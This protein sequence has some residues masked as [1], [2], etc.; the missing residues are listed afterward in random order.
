M[1]RT[2]VIQ[3]GGFRTAF[4]AGVL[5][6]FQSAK[7]NPFD[8][9]VA[10]SGGAIALS[11]Y[12]SRQPKAYY[13]AL[14]LLAEDKFFMDWSRIV[15]SQGVMN[16]DYFRKV[17]TE[18]IPLAVERAM[19][20]LKDKDIAIVLTN[21]TSGQPHYFRPDRKHW[22]D[23]IIATCTLPF[24]TKGSHTLKGEHFMDGGWSDPLPV[25]WAYE[26]GATELVVIRTTPS[27]VKLK[28]SWP[29]YIASFVYMMN[30]R[31]QS[32]FEKNHLKYNASVDFLLNPPEQLR[33]YEIAPESAL[34][35]GTYSNDVG[36]IMKDYEYGY[37]LGMS[38]LEQAA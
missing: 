18:V 9:Y 22:I 10:V 26:K 36:L 37:R 38:F 20:S 4:T 29:D 23:A 2:L 8:S 1:K 17:A 21:R 11:Y 14:K 25:K 27:D 3:G 7:H 32:C 16:V 28:Q 15:S 34:S 30:R 33:V 13:N 6:A 35:T 19:R 5:D 31:L 24:V 12:L